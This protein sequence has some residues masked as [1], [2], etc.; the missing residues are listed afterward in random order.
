[1]KKLKAGKK[2]VIKYSGEFCHCVGVKGITSFSQKGNSKD[3]IEAT[4]VGSVQTENEEIRNI[5]FSFDKDRSYIV[6]GPD[7]KTYVTKKLKNTK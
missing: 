1:M 4:F 5:F 7:F 6:M 2:Y 3:R